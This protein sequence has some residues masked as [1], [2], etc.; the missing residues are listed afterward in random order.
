MLDSP[1]TVSPQTLA[2][3]GALSAIV[4]AVVS[5]LFNLLTT[6]V[7]KHY[8]DRRHYREIVIKAAIENWKYRNDILQSDKPIRGNILPLDTYLIHMMKFAELFVGKKLT[9]ENIEKRL[10]ELDALN[11]KVMARNEKQMHQK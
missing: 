5:S 8:E 6:I 10:A 1:I 2:L 9:P 3:I 7:T 11:S 4:G